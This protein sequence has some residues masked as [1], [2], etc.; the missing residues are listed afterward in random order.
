[1]KA[2]F[3][4][5]WRSSTQPRK[6]R[7]FVAEAPLHIRKSLL[8]V[9]LSK[10][11]K[12]QYGKRSVVVKKGDTVKVL[13]GNHKGKSGKVERVSYKEYTIKIASITFTKKDGSNA[14]YPLDPSNCMITELDT[15]DAKRKKV[16][17][18]K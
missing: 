16:L 17:E 1:M 10:P 2:K 13:R 4:T 5:G 9:H 18:R 11:L 7:K 3:S 6:Q 14:L 12:E 8:S 15:S